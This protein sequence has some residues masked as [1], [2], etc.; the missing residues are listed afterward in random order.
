MN[1]GIK[2]QIETICRAT[3]NL[4]CCGF[5]IMRYDGLFLMVCDNSSTTPETQ[6]EIGIKNQIEATKQGSILYVWHSHP[7]AGGFSE[8]DIFYANNSA[9]KQK[10]F[11]VEENKWY[12]YIPPTYRFSP[13]EG[14]QWSWG[15]NDCF[16][17]IRDHYLK[18]GITLTDFDRDETSTGLGKIVLSNI[19]KE[20]FILTSFTM[21]KP[22]N[23]L[24]FRTNGS[25][26]HL[27]IFQGNS[28]VLHHPLDGLSRVQQINSTWCSRL[29]CVLKYKHPF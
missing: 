14:R 18:H 9:L 6:F 5:V 20:G 12:E 3:P 15:E 23:I 13:M 8:S 25:P 10:L 1:L 16:G 26:Q 28:R 11:N 4:E 7:R 27:G 19:E 29:E 22:H 21:I 2:N 24:V 17:L